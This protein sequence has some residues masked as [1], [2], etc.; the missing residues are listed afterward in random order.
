[1]FSIKGRLKSGGIRDKIGVVIYSSAILGFV[2]LSYYAITFFKE[3]LYSPY[4]YAYLVVGCVMLF[5][6]MNITSDFT[7]VNSVHKGSLKH[8][9]SKVNPAGRDIPRIIADLFSVN[10][11][12]AIN[13]IFYGILFFFIIGF[14]MFVF[15]HDPKMFIITGFFWF[16]LSVTLYLRIIMNNSLVTSK[17][18]NEIELIDELSEPE[19]NI[20]FSQIMSKI[21]GNGEIKRYELMKIIIDFEKSRTIEKSFLSKFCDIFNQ[22]K[23]EGCKVKNYEDFISRHN[24]AE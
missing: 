10:L 16:S 20:L 13:H 6:V 24:K 3:Y 18:L 22:N 9:V 1:M 21:K 17:T 19:K 5:S 8:F 23:D 12:N 7:N 15:K 11:M 2:F 4:Y 14:Y